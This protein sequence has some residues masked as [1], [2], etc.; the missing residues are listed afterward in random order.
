MGRHAHHEFQKTFRALET[1]CWQGNVV[2][3]NSAWSRDFLNQTWHVWPSPK[4]WADQ[5]QMLYLMINKKKGCFDFIQKKE[6][7]DKKELKMRE[8]ELREQK[9]MN[10]YL[11]DYRPGDFILHFVNMP[12]DQRM[13]LMRKYMKTVLY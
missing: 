11:K 2:I 3:K 5:S 6:C 13:P 9:T 8:V 4:P 7:C 10:S 12:M 1:C